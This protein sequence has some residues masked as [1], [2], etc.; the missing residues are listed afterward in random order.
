MK[1][2]FFSGM[3]RSLSK[4]GFGDGQAPYNNIGWQALVSM[5]AALQLVDLWRQE[6]GDTFLHTHKSAV[7]GG[8]TLTRIDYVLCPSCAT[9][10]PYGLHTSHDY[11]FWQGSG[12]ADHLGVSLKVAPSEVSKTGP[13][14]KAAPPYLFETTEWHTLHS[15]EWDAHICTATQHGCIWEW[16]ERW[17]QLRTQEL[18][19]VRAEATGSSS[20]TPPTV[21]FGG[22]SGNS[23]STEAASAESERPSREEIGTPPTERRETDEEFAKRK[24]KYDENNREIYSDL[25]I[26]CQGEALQLI[27][28]TPEGDGWG[29]FKSLREAYGNASANSQFMV[30]KA[31]IDLKQKGAIREHVNAFK[32]LLRRLNDMKITLVDSV[33]S[34]MF[35]RSLTSQYKQFASNAMMNGNMT[36]EK[37]YTAACEYSKAHLASSDEAKSKDLAM[38]VRTCPQGHGC[39]NWRNGNCQKFHPAPPANGNKRGPKRKARAALEEAGV[40]VLAGV[41]S[42]SHETYVRPK[43]ARTA[44]GRYWSTHDRLECCR[45]ATEGSS[46]WIGVGAWESSGPHTFWPDFPVVCQALQ[47]ELASE[48]LRDIRVY[49]GCG[50]AKPRSM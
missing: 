33:V 5:Q 14:N 30:I 17:T 4:I 10:G 6:N 47:A 32:Q 48:G 16:R 35:L 21:R 36:A 37:L 40:A 28:D 18:L 22:G 12:R 26:A 38:S 34:V 44:G 42:P 20:S 13:K 29:A 2:V 3:V 50:A 9:V 23:T 49:Y 31:L 11:A 43:M 24:D 45:R 39:N 19:R 46:D 25:V 15:K 41:L 8:F 7:P 1:Y 27:I